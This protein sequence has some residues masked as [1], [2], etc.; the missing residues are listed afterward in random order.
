MKLPIGNV[1][2]CHLIDPAEL[3]DQPYLTRRR[4]ANSLNVGLRYANPTYSTI[5]SLAAMV[6]FLAD[7]GEC[8]VTCFFLCCEGRADFV[9]QVGMSFHQL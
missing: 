1:S 6:L 4:F 9:K 7:G 3:L 5:I 2:L 8:G